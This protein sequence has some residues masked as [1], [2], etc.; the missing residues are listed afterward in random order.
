MRC[1]YQAV[2]ARAAS[3]LAGRIYKEC[4]R[5][6]IVPATLRGAFQTLERRTKGRAAPRGLPS[7]RPRGRR[8]ARM[9]LLS[10]PDR[11]TSRRFMSARETA[12]TGIAG[13]DDILA[14]GFT[15][16]RC[17]PR[18]RRAGLRQD[19]A[20]A[21]VPDGRRG[22]RRAGALRH[23]VGDR[24]TSSARSPSRT[25]G[26]STASTSASSRRPRRTLDPDEQN[27]M[28][29]PSEVE[30]AETTK[31]DP[32][33]TSSG[34]KPTRVVFDSLSEL[35]LLAGSAAALPPADPRAQAVLRDARSAPCCCSTT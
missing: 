9:L 2:R 20:R 6:S 12:S 31:R 10:P 35:R 24:A 17:L 13:L 5:P 11:W 26:R 30:L 29:H 15:R 1:P 33:R 8:A 3:A 23:A 18:R 27:T 14:G 22:R 21:A 19:D 4:G 16:E 28:F 7:S 32:R 34:S 25:A